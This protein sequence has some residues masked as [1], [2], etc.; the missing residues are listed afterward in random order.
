MTRRDFLL[1]GALA[2]LSLAGFLF[3]SAQGYGPG[4]P[5]DD[6]WIHQAYARNLANRGEWSLV[7]GEP[8]GGATSPMWVVLLAIGHLLR[9]DPIVWATVLGW[10]TLWGIGLLGANLFR[11]LAPQKSSW[12]IWAG[13]LLIFEWHLVWAALS[14]METALFAAVCLAAFL[15]VLRSHQREARFWIAAGALVGFAVTLRPEGITLLGPLAIAAYLAS[16]KLQSKV[17]RV[18]Q[19]FAGFLLLFI[20]YLLF[21]R[22]LSGEWWPNTLYA[23]QAEYASYLATPL[24]QRISEQW[25]AALVGVGLILLPGFIYFIYRSMQRRNW[26]PVL[27]AVWALGLPVLFA[28]RLAVVYQHARYAI[29]AMPIYFLI[30]LAGMAELARPSGSELWARTISR[31]WIASVAVIAVAF[32]AIGAKSAY[33]QDVGYIESE[34]VAA[35]K[36]V[37]ENTPAG[38]LIATHDI[39]AL[40]YFAQRPLLD[41]AGLIS[42][43]VIPFIRDES[44]LA[45]YLDEKGAEYLVTFPSWYPELVGRAEL[46]YSSG[47]DV[48]PQ[49]GGENIGVY[50]WTP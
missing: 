26:L 8:S 50:L 43:E 33:A 12:S 34:L 49:I 22:S 5:L 23:K 40:G 42:P 25:G 3:V 14:G 13:A 39:G 30:G 15:L 9:L 45:A 38:A 27:G 21:N 48:I 20:P 36:W 47:G 16:G 6:S 4:F 17:S 32:Y 11:A 19:L 35:A 10:L 46:I 7:A 18:L 1:L 24:W 2:A 29:P 31:A 28:V 41:L 37:N 44:R